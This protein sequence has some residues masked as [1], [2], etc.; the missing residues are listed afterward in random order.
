MKVLVVDDD[1]D[2]CMILQLIFQ[3]KGWE[4]SYV[5]DGKAALVWLEK[6]PADVVFL[7]LLMPEMNGDELLKKLKA[8]PKTANIPVILLTAKDLGSKEKAEFIGLGA[9]GVYTKPID[10]IHVIESATKFLKK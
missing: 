3:K 4:T 8:D 9:A 5:T 6:S 1:E 2:I 10:P 7:D